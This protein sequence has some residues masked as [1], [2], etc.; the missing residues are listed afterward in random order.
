MFSDARKHCANLPSLQIV[1]RDL[2][3][4][5]QTPDE[6]LAR[7]R[8][9]ILFAARRDLPQPIPGILTI[10]I[11]VGTDT[12]PIPRR[13]P[14]I[15]AGARDRPRRSSRQGSRCAA[16]SPPRVSWVQLSRRGALICAAFLR[17]DDDEEA[18]SDQKSRTTRKTALFAGRATACSFPTQGTPFVPA[19]QHLQQTVILCSLLDFLG[20]A[21][22]KRAQKL[23]AH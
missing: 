10:P 16:L 6:A 19:E 11:S 4:H 14:V 23:G 5:L 21:C 7:A 9:P 3:T 22:I 8:T 1:S 12:Y 13:A 15:C 2:E 20:R 17:V 18:C